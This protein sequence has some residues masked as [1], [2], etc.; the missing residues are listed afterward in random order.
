MGFPDTPSRC[1]IFFSSLKRRYKHDSEHQRR[2]CY[3]TNFS[4]FLTIIS[5][6]SVTL[7]SLGIRDT[8]STFTAFLL[9]RQ[10]IQ[11]RGAN[12]CCISSDRH[13]DGRTDG[14]NV[15]QQWKPPLTAT[16]AALLT[17]TR[18]PKPPTAHQKLYQWT[19]DMNGVVACVGERVNERQRM[20]D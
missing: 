10:R 7:W 16:W 19:D 14:P 8:C 3:A 11:Q 20:S 5:H 2:L 13:T 6:T 17:S 18:C 9:T 1:Y 12:S 4:G 15:I